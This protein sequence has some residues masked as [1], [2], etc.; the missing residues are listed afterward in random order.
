MCV[1]LVCIVVACVCYVVVDCFCCVSCCVVLLCL[2]CC[3]LVC[4]E[5]DLVSLLSWFCVCLGWALFF[6]C[7]F[8]LLCV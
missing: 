4:V 6:V 8:V 3:A 5:F 7:V 1:C 2:L